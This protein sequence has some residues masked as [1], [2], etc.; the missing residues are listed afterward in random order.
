[1]GSIPSEE[2]NSSFHA[3]LFPF[4]SKGHTIPLLHF[5]RLLLR[6]NFSV[7]LFTTTANR[8]FIADS[9]SGTAAS[10][11][12][13]PFTVSTTNNDIPPGIESTDKLPSMSLFFEFAMATAS[14]QPHFEQA[15]ETLPRV[16]FMVT[17]GFLWWTLQSANKFHI[18]RLVFFGMSC[19]SVSVFREA[20]MQGIFRGPQPDDELV[21]LTRFPWI[22]ICKEDLEPSSRNA[23]PG[24]IP[25]EF[26]VKSVGAS[27]NSYGTVVNSFYELEP[28]FVD[29][30]KTTN[31]SH[32]YWCVGPLCL[33][34]D[35]G[36]FSG[37]KEPKWMTWLHQKKKCSV[38]YVAFGSQAEISNEELEEIAMGLEESMV[39]FL[40]VIRKKDWVLPKGF[41]ERVEGRGMAVREWVDQREILN[42]ERVGGYVSHCGWNSVVESVCGGVPMVAWPMMAEQHV[43][44][45]MVEE[46]LKVGIRMETCDGK[47]RGSVKRE[48][49]SK[50]VKELMEGERGIQLRQNVKVLARLARM[51]VQE[52]GSSWSALDHL[53]HELCG[54]K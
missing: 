32:K 8:P 11:V 52:G 33:A 25:Y 23:E 44:A 4:M 39:S 45:R 29:Y 30:L 14:I 16:S 10:I 36:S 19:Y 13:L 53:I 42:D 28:L 21:E 51:A 38:L 12:T 6:R 48:G 24:S 34:D 2:F 22:K 27:V 15:L 1:M 7:T 17:D 50:C 26:N 49:V 9:L 41:E 5:A 43:N 54:K 46:E 37:T 3:L 47:V 40:W 20:E 35:V 31:T 18:P